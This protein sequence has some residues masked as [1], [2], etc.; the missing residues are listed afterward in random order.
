[1]VLGV[2]FVVVV[3][4]VAPPQQQQIACLGYR[5]PEKGRVFAQLLTKWVNSA[6]DLHND[7]DGSS[8]GYPWLQRLSRSV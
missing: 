5:I 4:A 2:V 3:V 6:G 7:V 8:L 1:V